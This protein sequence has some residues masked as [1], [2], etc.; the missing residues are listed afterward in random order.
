M[1]SRGARVLLAAPTDGSV[2]IEEID[3]PIAPAAHP[4]L[5]A[6]SAIQSFYYLVES[7]SRARGMNP[8]APRFLSK[9]TLTH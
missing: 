3:L 1:R 4:V 6:M 2:S 7:L 5:D 8:D 9:V